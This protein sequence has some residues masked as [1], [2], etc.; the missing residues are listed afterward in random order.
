MAEHGLDEKVIGIAFDG[1]GLGDDHS[2]WGGE[3]LLCD[4]VSYQRF[5]HLEPVYLPGGDAATKNPWRTALAYL[6]R[7]YGMDS[8][9]TNLPFLGKIPEEEANLVLHAVDRRINA[10]VTTSMGRFFDA[11]AAL[12]DV[13]THSLFH[14]EAPMR[15]E[16]L[17]APGVKDSYPYKINNTIETRSIIETIAEDIKKG[18]PGSVISSR[19]HNTIIDIIF[20]AAEKCRA[21]TGIK[22]VALS[23][24]T[25]QNRYILENTEKK[26]SASGFEVFSQEKIPCN[27]GGIALGQMVIA[28]KRAHL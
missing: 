27:D 13:C 18:I 26:L 10:P 21:E 3:I 8:I 7:S 12:L 19:F 11:V 23:G 2:I 4:L 20:A 28:A 15:L 17:L 16:Q 25:F 6:H 1:T 9:D 14:A 24:G 22:K 5:S